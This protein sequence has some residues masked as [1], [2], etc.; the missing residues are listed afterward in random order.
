MVGSRIV[1][2]VPPVV[3]RWTFPPAVILPIGLTA[4]AY[5]RGVVAARRRTPSR[6]WTPEAVWFLGGLALVLVALCSP[7]DTLADESLAVHMV[8]HLVL[9]LVAPPLLLLGRPL[10]LAHAAT[11]ARTSGMLVRLART[12]VARCVAA[13]VFGFASFALVLWWSHM[14]SFYEATLTDVRLHAVE[15]VTYLVTACLFWWPV[16]ARDPGARRLSYPGRLF[17]LFLAMP[18]MSLLGFVISSADRVLY[19]H[20]VVSAGSVAGALADQRLAGALMWESSMLGGVIALS[21][22]LIAWMKFDDAEARRADLRTRPV[23]VTE[24]TRG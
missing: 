15:H 16:V 7:L 18:V 19:P 9:T 8:Q 23:S 20:Y 4:V 12:R 1:A 22:A 2:V 21:L 11:S 6:S 24:A 3:F 14:S 10:T 13:P 17:Y 5:L